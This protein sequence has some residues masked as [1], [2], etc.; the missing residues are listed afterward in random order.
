MTPVVEIERNQHWTDSRGETVR[1]LGVVEGHV[2]WR[3][4]GAMA[5]VCTIRDFRER[6]K[7]GR[8]GAK[9]ARWS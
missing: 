3:Y 7:F 4:K 1:V 9:S 2:V 6:F 5:N 8:R